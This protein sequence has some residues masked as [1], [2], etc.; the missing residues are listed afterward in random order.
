VAAQCL[1]SLR[2]AEHGLLLVEFDLLA[3]LRRAAGP[4]GMSAGALAD[5]AMVTPGAITN[6]VDRLVA[7]NLVTRDLDPANRRVTLIAL[8]AA[9]RDLI[10]PALVDHVSNEHRILAGIAAG[11]RTQLAD[12]LRA[13]L[14]SLGDVPSAPDRTLAAPD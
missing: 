4:S 2:A 13:L 7:K 1:E 10:D 9:G 12:L 5:A 14:I 3:T 11:Q 8:T 6:R